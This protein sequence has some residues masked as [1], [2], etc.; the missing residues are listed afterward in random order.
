MDNIY[1]DIEK[2]AF[3]SKAVLSALPHDRISAGY[4]SLP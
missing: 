3:F 4:H 2:F 1:E